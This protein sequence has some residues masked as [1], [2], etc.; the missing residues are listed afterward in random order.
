MHALE[1]YTH[2]K[3]V[4][5]DC[6]VVVLTAAVLIG[7][8]AAAT[9]STAT[10][11]FT[12]LIRNVTVIDATGA[13]P[14]PGMS[15]FI[16][17]DRITAIT[18][19]GAPST[20]GGEIID[21]TGQFL[22]PGLR[23]MHVHLGAYEDARAKMERLLAAGVI[24]VRDMA[25]PPD[26]VLKLRGE[27]GDGRLIAAG[28]IVQGPLPFDVPPMIRTVATPAAA[29]ALVA[30]LSALRVDFIKTGDTL[31]RDLY[32]ALAAEANRRGVPFAG[33]LPAYVDAAHASDLGQRSIEHFGSATFHGLLLA[34]SREQVDLSRIVRDTLTAA[35]AGGPAPDSVLF[36]DPF[37][38]RLARGYDPA[39]AA[40][41]FAR[42]ARNGTWQTPTMTAVDQV[43]AARS[44][45]LNE[46]EKAAA[47]TVLTTYET[48]LRGMRDARVKLLAGTDFETDT[49]VA[50]HDEI[51]RLVA[52]GLS[53]LEALQS[54]TRNPAE[55][56]G[57][58]AT[59]G[60]I[61]AGKRADLVL[62]KANPLD[63]IENIRGVTAVVLG[64][65][66]VR[67]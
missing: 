64:G 32:E 41:L 31:R 60:T 25:S 47:R 21:G 50:L 37:L 5:V 42:F 3:S 17:G 14:K 54:A 49:G 66:I 62:L 36:K 61:E 22:I 24:G 39:K 44:K 28:P 23:D 1:H 48:M 9:R 12:L 63:R 43:W 33:H 57:R 8:C 20:A 4:W 6:L 55:F 40:A 7:G 46:T 16:T 52:A 67:R 18:S 26:D 35:F 51:V 59:E 53:P 45:D 29:A 30:E 34:C 27:L 2:V 65:R 15:V 13:A 11:P 56:L 38:S 58:L 19:S 10:P